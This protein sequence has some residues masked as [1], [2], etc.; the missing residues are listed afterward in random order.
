MIGTGGSEGGAT[1]AN[2]EI[3][4]I[5]ILTASIVAIGAAGVTFAGDSASDTSEQMDQ[6]DFEYDGLDIVYVDGPVLSQPGEPERIRVNVDDDTTRIA[7]ND[8]TNWEFVPGDRLLTSGQLNYLDIEH[9]STIEIVWDRRNGDSEVVE[10]IYIPDEEVTGES[11]NPGNESVEA[12][13]TE[14]SGDVEIL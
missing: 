13:A 14:M 9:D 6:P 4:F 1:R 2:A 8:S 12:D 7:Y 5:A 10:E 3:L 11:T